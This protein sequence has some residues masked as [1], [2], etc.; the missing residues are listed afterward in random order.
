M[1]L[2]KAISGGGLAESSW[3]TDEPSREGFP[4]WALAVGAGRI[5]GQVGRGSDPLL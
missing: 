2:C 3:L 1:I 4:K 5:L